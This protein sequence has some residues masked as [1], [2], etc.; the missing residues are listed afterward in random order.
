MRFAFPLVLAAA[1]SSRSRSP[2]PGNSPV[3]GILNYIHAVNNSSTG[4]W[5]SITKFSVWMATRRPFPNPGVPA[6]TNSPG[7]TL[8]LGTLRLPNAGFGMELTEFSAADR[9]LPVRLGAPIPALPP[10]SYP[11]RTSIPSSWPTSK[12]NALHHHH[13]RRSGQTRS[14][15]HPRAFVRSSSATPTATS[16]KWCKPSR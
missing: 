14:Q 10:S 3:V 11:S 8:R 6:L 13:F 1:W 2:L 7:V 12:T 9:K 15:R 5:P 16:F 4:P